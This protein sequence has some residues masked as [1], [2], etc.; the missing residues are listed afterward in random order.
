MI[1]EE[2][3]QSVLETHRMAHIDKLLKKYQKKRK[4]VKE[5]LENEYSNYIYSPLNS[6]SYAKSTAINS[7]FDLDV[8]VPFKRNSFDTLEKMFD[9]V[10]DFL[11]EKYNGK[12][13]VRRQKVSIGIEFYPDK[14]GD[15]INLDIVPGREL[16][17]DTYKDTRDINLMF[18]E[19][20]GFIEKNSYIKTNIQKQIEHIKAKENERKIIRLLKIWKHENSEKY[21]SFLLELITIKAFAKVEV[22]G[23]LWK[24]LKTV[25]EYIRD[26]VAEDNFKL[27][28]PGNKSND[29]MET[30]DYSQRRNL[31]NRMGLMIDRIKDNSE[32]IKNYF[33]VNDEFADDD[34]YCIKG[35]VIGSS[36]PPNDQRFG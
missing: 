18:N 26:N 34:S 28:D 7:K 1:I 10:Y 12:A 25:M 30:L 3:L 13:E 9:D 29:V 4:K 35:S 31:S 24:Q 14:N 17:Q 22:S 33:P 5:A 11:Y 32:N 21:K 27:K 16:N 8:V 15:I 6:G 23:N 36:T 2:Y 20:T 19:K